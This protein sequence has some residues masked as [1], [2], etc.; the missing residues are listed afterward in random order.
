MAGFGFG[1]TGAARPGSVGR[2]DSGEVKLRSLGD[3]DGSR[4]VGV[5]LLTGGSSRHHCWSDAMNERNAICA[6]RRDYLGPR[7]VAEELQGL[8]RPTALVRAFEAR[9][10]RLYWIEAEWRTSKS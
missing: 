1:D 5:G 8:L 9:L 7:S 10:R 4:G 3:S 6:R 2:D